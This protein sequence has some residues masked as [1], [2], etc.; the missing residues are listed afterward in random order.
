[1]LRD[2]TDYSSNG[3]AAWIHREIFLV[4]SS[5]SRWTRNS[6]SS[7]RTGGNSKLSLQRASGNS[8][9]R[10]RGSF[11]EPTTTTSGNTHHPSIFTIIIKYH[12]L[13]VENRIPLMKICDAVMVTMPVINIH[14]LGSNLSIGCSVNDLNPIQ[15][16]RIVL[17][18][19]LC[20]WKWHL[21]TYDTSQERKRQRKSH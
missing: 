6:R 20:E 9:T 19:L 8:V 7:F 12:L 11:N 5:R 15:S 17:A 21:V 1:M 18:R 10:P 4:N 14:R 16:M 13:L 2:W 3:A